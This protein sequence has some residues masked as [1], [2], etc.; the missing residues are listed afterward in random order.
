MTTALSLHERVCRG[1]QVQGAWPLLRECPCL[2]GPDHDVH[3]WLC[4][5]NDKTF[6][7]ATC[8]EPCHGTGR[9]PLAEA[10]SLE[11]LLVALAPYHVEVEAFED[12]NW[13]AFVAKLHRGNGKT[14]LAAL[15][16][17]VVAAGL[18]GEAQG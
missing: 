7:H 11:P 9:V 2:K 18:L 16:Q 3:C 12:G 8:C 13:M 6:I 5:W 17:A 1:L 4:G 10:E 14:P 15:E